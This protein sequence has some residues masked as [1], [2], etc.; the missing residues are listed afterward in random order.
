MDFS[1]EV[2]FIVV[3]QDIN[4]NFAPPDLQFGVSH[5]FVFVVLFHFYPRIANYFDH[6]KYSRVPAG[7]VTFHFASVSGEIITLVLGV[8]TTHVHF[9]FELIL[10]PLVKCEDFRQLGV[11]LFQFRI[12]LGH[13]VHGFDIL[14]SWVVSDLVPW[15]LRVRVTGL[16][17][18]GYLLS[19]FTHVT[20]LT[21]HE[22]A[23]NVYTTSLSFIFVMIEDKFRSFLV[24]L[25]ELA[26]LHDL[27]C[28]NISLLSATCGIC[29]HCSFS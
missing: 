4:G 29:L 5:L 16:H 27:E 9:S 13:E 25:L 24:F 10:E 1:A 18:L 28:I 22:A 19:V 2:I 11:S 17:V 6:R 21:A 14:E 23:T 3:L 15:M 20:T 7:H 8:M 12:R 26:E